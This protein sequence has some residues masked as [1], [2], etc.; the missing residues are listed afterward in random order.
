MLLSV[1]IPTCNRNDLL[2]K[3][4]SCLSPGNQTLSSQLYE[5]IVT[6]DSGHNGA[7]NLIEDKFPWVRWVEGPKKGPAANRNNGTKYAKG[8]WLVFTD[9][10]C[11][12]VPNWVKAFADAIT[13]EGYKVYEGLTDADR[14]KER[15]DEQCPLNLTGGRLWSCN[16]AIRKDFFDE[17]EGFDEQYP[18]AALEDMDLYVRILKEQPVSFTPEAKVIHPWRIVK[19]FKTYYKLLVSYRY[20]AKKHNQY[21]SFNYR[22]SRVKIFFCS[23]PHNFKSL[24]KYSFKGTGYYLEL[25]WLNLLLIFA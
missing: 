8:D 16:F 23:I 3:C 24:Q 12:P 6:D 25:T 11:L 4:L 19:P 7:K 2:A 9:D 14:P 5:V 10:D 13:T 17:L 20:F 18:Y 15:F 21:G 22:W 1:I